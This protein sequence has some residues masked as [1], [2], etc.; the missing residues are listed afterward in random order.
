MPKKEHPIHP[1]AY[2]AIV[3]F[4][5]LVAGL[6]WM[7]KGVGD[8]HL[9]S[10]A[11]YTCAQ[12]KY[13]RAE[14]YLQKVVLTLQDGKV[15]ALPQTIAASGIRY[16]NDNESF[17]FWSKGNTAFVTEGNPP[18]ETY[19]NCITASVLPEPEEGWTTYSKPLSHYSVAYPQ[20]YAINQQYMYTGLGGGKEIKGTKFTIGAT[21]TEGTNLSTD[22]GVSVEEIS[23]PAVCTAARFLYTPQNIR[24]VSE[25]GIDYSVADE[26]G[27]GAGNFYEE[28]VYAIPGTEPCLAVR[29]FIHSTNI[30]NYEPGTVTE[31]D[32]TA[33]L[34]EFDKIRASLKII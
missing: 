9:M 31:F 17:V 14:Y 26:G 8:N 34:K 19:T 1:F 33:L 3:I 16:A 5:A 25:N 10:S 12:E 23:N 2:I 21:T 30:G 7:N 29:Y 15:V 28:R 13:I 24:T 6:L 20:A 32:K 4:I 27:A 11:T 18:V 22:T